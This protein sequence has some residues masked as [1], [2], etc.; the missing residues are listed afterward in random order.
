MGSSRANFRG[1]MVMEKQKGQ[2]IVE[3]ALVFPFFLAILFAI[4]LSGLM[5]ADYMTLSNVAR[6]S[7]REAALGGDTTE[8]SETYRQNTR[9]M[10]NLYIWPEDGAIVFSDGS[11]Q[12]SITAT[13][14]T[15]LNKQFPAVGFLDAVGM[16]LPET[17]TITY[18]MHS[19]VTQNE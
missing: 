9:L 7:A 6:S 13:I 19:E 2:A 14:T 1:R 3:F 10:T 8:I 16:S 15:T 11:I 18:T 12:N 4:L 5:F 17:Y